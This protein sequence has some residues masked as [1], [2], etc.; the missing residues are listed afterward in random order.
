MR[1]I[2]NFEEWNEQMSRKFN[3]DTYREKSHWFI[4]WVERMRDRVILR[5][6]NVGDRDSVIDLGCGAGHLLSKIGCGHL[7]GV[8]L[9]E[10]SLELARRRLGN[11]AELIKGDVGALL[12]SLNGRRFD[13]IVCSEV[14]EHVLS[15]D[16][17]IEQIVR[18][19][20]PTSVIVISVPYEKLID[21]LKGMFIRL[22]IFQHLFPNIPE[23]NT[24]E[25]HLW[26]FDRALFEELIAGRLVV[27]KTRR[28]P[29]ALLPL[30]YVFVC[31]VVP[32]GR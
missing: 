22:G 10:F 25:W 27:T 29:F 9:S 32:S 13:K 11:R 24:E 4:R 19:A 23:S 6:L 18:I 8:D 31:K 1:E 7:T 14:I 2:E 21:F 28:I 20:T 17:V 16:K 30:R 26:A 15:P 5:Y 12:V 3:I